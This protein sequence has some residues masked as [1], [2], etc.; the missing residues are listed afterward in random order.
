MNVLD[1]VGVYNTIPKETCKSLIKTFKKVKYNLHQWQDVN[2]NTVGSRPNKKEEL[3]NYMMNA[4]EQ[5]T[6]VPFIT[7]AVSQYRHDLFSCYPDLHIHEKQQIIYKL[8]RFRVNKYDKNTN[9]ALHVD[10]IH[11]IFDGKERGVPILS[12]I[13]LLNDNFKGGEFYVCNQKIN[14][15]RGDVLIFPSNFIY[16][17]EVKSITKGTRYSFI[18]WGY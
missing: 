4:E 14:L 10:N 13:G 11:D 8:S 1:F 18:T 5:N 3:K 17:H 9:M 12:L 6:L 2:G 16:P 7:K 15:K